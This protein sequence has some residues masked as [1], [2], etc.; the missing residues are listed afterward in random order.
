MSCTKIF[1]LKNLCT[2]C[3]LCPDC[4][5]PL[6][7]LNLLNSYWYITFQLEKSILGR[8]FS[9]TSHPS[10]IPVGPCYL[11]VYLRSSL[12]LYCSV[13]STESAAGFH[14]FIRLGSQNFWIWV[15]MFSINSGKFPSNITPASPFLVSIWNLKKMHL[16]CFSSLMSLHLFIIFV[17]LCDCLGILSDFFWYTNF[18]FN[19][20]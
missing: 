6:P 16:G 15:F 14:L 1:C 10:W 17:L 8:V 12:C 5:L 11:W 7:S 19:S 13:I 2:F 3:S 20:V 18:L 4:C 9:A